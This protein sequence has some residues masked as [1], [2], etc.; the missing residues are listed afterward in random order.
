MAI[1]SIKQTQH[2]VTAGNL[3]FKVYQ[4]HD[5]WHVGF[6]GGNNATD[7]H[8]PAELVERMAAALEQFRLKTDAWEDRQDVCAVHGYFKRAQGFDCPKC[9]A[10]ESKPDLPTPVPVLV[11]R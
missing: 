11:A 4:S 2:L 10:A 8:A 7:F 6:D 1:V 3:E 9:V 5:G